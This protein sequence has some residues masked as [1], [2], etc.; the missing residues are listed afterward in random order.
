MLEAGV[1]G[2]AH[3]ERQPQS[4]SRALRLGAQLGRRLLREPDDLLVV[5]EVVVAQ[6]GVAVEAETAHDDAVE[7]ADEEVREEVRRRLVFRSV[8]LV[9][10]RAVELLEPGEIG[11]AVGVGDEHV[12]AVRGLL[13]RRA[14]PLGTVVQLGRHRAHFEVPPTPG[15]DPLHVQSEGSAGD[16]D[17]SRLRLPDLVRTRSRRFGRP[18]AIRLTERGPENRDLVRTRSRF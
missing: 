10:V 9:A 6:L 14:D 4:R 5:A 2:L 17:M 11:S 8:H 13:D 3:L 15:G 12:V 16:D 7:A 1:P 18:R